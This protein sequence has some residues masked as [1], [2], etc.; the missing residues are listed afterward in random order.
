MKF[1][2][3]TNKIRIRITNC[4]IR[5]QNENKLSDLNN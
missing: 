3:P 2:I 4:Y 1:E 5:K